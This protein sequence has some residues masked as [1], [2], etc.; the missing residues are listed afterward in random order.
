MHQVTGGL[1]LDVGILVGILGL[2][3]RVST[4]GIQQ[5]VHGGGSGEK[6][7]K[8]IREGTW[9]RSSLHQFVDRAF[10]LMHDLREGQ[11]NVNDL[12]EG[13]LPRPLYPPL[14]VPPTGSSPPPFGG[15]RRGGLGTAPGC[16]QHNWERLGE[17]QLRH[18][19]R[20]C[21]RAVRE[22]NSGKWGKFVQNSYEFQ[23]LVNLL[24]LR[25]SLCEFRLLISDST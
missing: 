1:H 18:G 16:R 20:K 7:Q 15:G 3:H 13:M 4:H 11:V 14:K 5:F 9:K 25:E 22:G 24:M 12:G 10:P 19:Q 6:V 21:Q 2:P 23:S 17:G 8:K